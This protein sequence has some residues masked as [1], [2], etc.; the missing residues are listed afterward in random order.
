MQHGE[1][2]VGRRKGHKM[3]VKYFKG[4]PSFPFEGKTGGVISVWEM[5]LARDEVVAPHSHPTGVELYVVVD[6]IGEMTAEPRW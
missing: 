1:G 6:G 4:N 3:E 2:Q 5:R